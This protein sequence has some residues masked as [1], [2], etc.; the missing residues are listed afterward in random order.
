MHI[1]ELIS[2][3]GDCVCLE[4]QWVT[5]VIKLNKENQ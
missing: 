4:Y 1:S 2:A 5:Q 3:C